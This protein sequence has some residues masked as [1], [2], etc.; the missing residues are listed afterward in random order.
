MEIFGVLVGKNCSAKATLE[1]GHGLFFIGIIVVERATASF[2]WK[3]WSHPSTCRVSGNAAVGRTI[4]GKSMLRRSL[5]ESIID[6]LCYASI[7]FRII[8]GQAAKSNYG[9]QHRAL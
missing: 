8:Q 9:C 4:V 6:K 1:T 7:V 5:N 2:S 3:K